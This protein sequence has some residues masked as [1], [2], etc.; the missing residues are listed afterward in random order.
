MIRTSIRLVL[1]LLTSLVLASP[2]LAQDDDDATLKPAEP[3]FNVVNIPTS[4][5]LPQWKSA[6][7]ITHRFARPLKCDNCPRSLAGDAFGIDGGAVIGLEYR[8]GLAPRLQFAAQRSALERTV[9]FLFQY[10]VTRQNE[11]MPLEIGAIASFEGTENFQGVYSQAFGAALT[12]MFGDK[13]AIHVDPI[14]VHNSNIL[15]DFGDDDTF[16]IGLGGRVNAGPIALVGEV[17]PRVSGFSPGRSLGAFAIEKRLGGHIFQLTF[18]NY[19]STTLRRIA[20]G[21]EDNNNWYLGF[22]LTRKFF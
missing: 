19:F 2:V 17:T 9:Q 16:M 3:D 12:R 11:S 7:R 6:I 4:L 1:V 20:V 13:A 5:N 10:G 21:A 15:S 18:T 22:N 14:W 8:L